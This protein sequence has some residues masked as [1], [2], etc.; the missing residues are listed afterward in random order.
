[1][2]EDAALKVE[3]LVVGV[4]EVPVVEVTAG[5]MAVE[6][7]S[8][9]VVLA[10]TEPVVAEVEFEVELDEALDETVGPIENDADEA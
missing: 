8:L 1:L 6:V 2:R 9:P 10:V 4:D 3:E 5:D 7:V